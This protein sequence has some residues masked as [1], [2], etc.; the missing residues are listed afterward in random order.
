MLENTFCHI[1]GISREMERS[2][3]STGIDSWQSFLGQT[4]PPF[5]P[6]RFH[7]ATK[8]IRESIHNL[9]ISNPLYFCGLLPSREHWRLFPHFRQAIAYLDIETTGLARHGDAITTIALYDGEVVHHYV[10]GE[11]L[12]AFKEDILRY[13]L[14]VTYNGKCFDLPFIES[15]LGI[16]MRQAHIDL[17]YVLRSLGLKGGL[18]GC[19]KQ[20]GLDRGEL[21]GVDGWFAVHLWDDYHRNGN[22]AALETLLAYNIEDVVN[23]ETLMVTAYNLKLRE[24]PFSASHQLPLPRR[25]AVPF[26]ADRETINRIRRRHYHY[27]L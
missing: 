4:A 25:P 12:E 7:A 3:W 13:A 8:R 2:L 27:P 17:M 21:D 14:L 1:P 20:L 15:G 16:P 6:T 24:T 18:K 5:P 11:N 19:E 10:Q 9:T 22:M 26:K 23:L